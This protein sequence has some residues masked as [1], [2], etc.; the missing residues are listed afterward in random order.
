MKRMLLIVLPIRPSHS[1]VPATRQPPTSFQQVS[2]TNIP[3]V[4]GLT[5][6]DQSDRSGCVS[7]LRS[8]SVPFNQELVGLRS[9]FRR[10][11]AKW[12]A[13]L[14]RD[15][16]AKRPAV[17]TTAPTL[18]VPQGY[19]GSRSWKPHSSG[20]RLG[21]GMDHRPL[22]PTARFVDIPATSYWT[23]VAGNES[24]QIIVASKCVPEPSTLVIACLD[25]S[26][27]FVRLGWKRTKSRVTSS[28]SR[29]FLLNSCP[30]N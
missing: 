23:Q 1:Y 6:L 4:A 22:S 14:A 11:Q 28:Q 18:W 17:P 27:C 12:K 10:R 19:H 5:H 13:F 15:A 25:G 2:T 29:S 9:Q 30:C 3:A 26:T 7:V 16:V 20:Q 24:A 21:L 8:G